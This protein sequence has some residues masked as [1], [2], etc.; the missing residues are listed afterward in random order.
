MEFRRSPSQHGCPNDRGFT[1]VIRR[2]T[3]LF[4]S[5]A[6]PH[7]SAGTSQGAGRRGHVIQNDDKSLADPGPAPG[8]L[9]ADCPRHVCFP[10]AGGHVRLRWA[11]VAGEGLGNFAPGAIG[12][13]AGDGERVVDAA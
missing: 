11:V 2:A 7:C 13:A 5:E 6:L 12:D 8:W 9:G 3:R 4:I 10:A 1:P